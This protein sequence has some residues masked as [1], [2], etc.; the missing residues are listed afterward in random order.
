MG[1][2]KINKIAFNAFE[3]VYGL[4][5]GAAFVSNWVYKKTAI[6]Q[7]LRGVI[8]ATCFTD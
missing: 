2:Y 5:K 3:E 7:H 6:T 1:K 4:D 8:H